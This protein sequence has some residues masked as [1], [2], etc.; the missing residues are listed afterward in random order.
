MSFPPFLRPTDWI[1]T[2]NLTAEISK[3]P[4]NS[5]I[6]LMSKLFEIQSIFRSDRRTAESNGT[7]YQ[8]LATSFVHE[9]L[10]VTARTVRL[11]WYRRLSVQ[12][13]YLYEE[14]GRQHLDE[15]RVAWGFIWDPGKWIV[16]YDAN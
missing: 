12:K 2:A 4:L 14:A 5:Q 10:Q 9:G 1:F 3:M 13:E 6:Q 11:S 8:G 7:R 15:K 16:I